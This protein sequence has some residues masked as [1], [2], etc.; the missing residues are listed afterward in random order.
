[1]TASQTD[2]ASRRFFVWRARHASEVDDPQ[3]VWAAAWHYGGRDALLRSGELAG[4]VPRLEELAEL[5][6][7]TEEDLDA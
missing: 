2:E 7:M 6:R 4:L 1:M 5:F 3:A